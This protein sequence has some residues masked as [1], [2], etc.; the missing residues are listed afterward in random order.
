M[1]DKEKFKQNARQFIEDTLMAANGR[2]PDTTSVA[3]ATN[4]LVE[5]FSPILDCTDSIVDNEDSER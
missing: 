4:K 1:K 2:K 5:T 3:L